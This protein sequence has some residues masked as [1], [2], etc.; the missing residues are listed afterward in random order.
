MAIL[1]IILI[2]IAVGYVALLVVLYALQD[3]FI[4]FPTHEIFATPAQ[5]GLRFEDVQIVAED[6]I[7]LHGWFVPA[8]A[9]RATV[10]FLHGNGGNLAHTVEAI[11]TFARLGMS[12]FAI[13]YRGYG[14]SDG[15]PSGDGIALDAEAAW[16]HLTVERGIAE[17]A[18]VI[19]GRS[20]GGGPA[21]MLAARYD[22]AA[23]ILESTYTSLPDR[24]A[25]QFPF[26]PARWIVRTRFDNRAS[27]A[28]V[29]CPVLIVHSEHD[30]TIPYH[31]G[32]E[33]FETAHEPKSLVT[34]AYGH[35]DGFARSADVYVAALDG[36]VADHIIARR[37]P[38]PDSETH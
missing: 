34:I 22:P 33:L 25:E 2:I 28:H 14:K 8:P 24:A 6:G 23:L 18:I 7:R 12:V 37:E 1:K 21:S 16:R 38:L 35:N 13:D 19:V 17:D 36:F 32:R 26:F 27:L 29:K 31:H 20:L 10:L 30:E 3:R 4:F 9:P 15:S 5:R 11:E